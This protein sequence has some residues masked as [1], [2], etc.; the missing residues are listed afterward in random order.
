[1]AASCRI[2]AAFAMQWYCVGLRLR[3]CASSKARVSLLCKL[4]RRYYCLLRLIWSRTCSHF[5]C[6]VERGVNAAYLFVRCQIEITDDSGDWWT[7]RPK[8]TQECGFFP[9]NYVKKVLS[10]RRRRNAFRLGCIMLVGCDLSRVG[11]GRQCCC[12]IIVRTLLPCACVP[13]QVL[14]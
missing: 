9:S 10:R 8:G 4:G 1:M 5:W 13:T 2:S 12:E 7:G 11:K 3:Y 14:V 6:C